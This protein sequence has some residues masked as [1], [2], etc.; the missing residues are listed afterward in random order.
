MNVRMSLRREIAA[1]N[2][3]RERLD[4]QLP[5]AETRLGH[6]LQVEH[7]VLHHHR[8]HACPLE[9]ST[10]ER[11]DMAKPAGDVTS[12]PPIVGRD[13]PAKQTQSKLRNTAP[14]LGFGWK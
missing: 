3:G 6:V 4:Q 10:A 14:V 1:A 8:A 9:V 12:C 7:P 13:E 2:P 5:G 11:A